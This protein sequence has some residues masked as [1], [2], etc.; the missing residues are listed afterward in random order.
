MT[1][2]AALAGAVLYLAL[3]TVVSLPETP[4]SA[5]RLPR[6]SIGDPVQMAWFL[7]W[8]AHAVLHGH[9]LF[10]TRVLDFPDGVNLALNTTVPVLGLAVLPVTA[11]AGPVVSFNL[12]AHL[13]LAASAT[14][15]YLVARRYVPSA[16]AA[17]LAG[18]LYGFGPYAAAH[19]QHLDLAFA[20]VPP[21]VLWCLDELF[22]RQ[23]RRPVRVGLALG[24]LA[25]FQAL[26]APEIL[27]TTAVLAAVGLA[28]L[29]LHRPR[30]VL[31]RLRRALPGLAA[32]A[33]LAGALCAYPLAYMLD[34]PQH[35][36]G[37]VQPLP[38]LQAL[39]ADLLSAV[40][41]TRH[42]WI[43][44]ASLRV[45]ADGFY[46]KNLSENAGYLGI[47]LL[48]FAIFVTIWR[49]KDGIVAVSAL[50]GGVAFLLSLGPRL[51]VDGHLTSVPLPF[52]LFAHVPLLDSAVP[53]REAL[54]VDLFAGLLLARGVDALRVRAAARRAARAGEVRRRPGRRRVGAALRPSLVAGAVGAAA[55]VPALPSLPFP[56]W[57]IRPGLAVDRVLAAHLPPRA[58]VLSYP[59]PSSSSDDTIMLWQAEGGLRYRLVGGYAIDPGPDRAGRV[60]APLL[61]PPS[62]EE[63]LAHDADVYEGMYPAPPPLSPAV[64]ADLRTF[65]GRYRVD[66]VIWTPV[67]D[68]PR[69]AFAYL[70]GGLGP[71]S[72]RVG[73]AAVWVDVPAI[74]ARAGTALS[75]PSA[76]T[77]PPP[78]GPN[79]ARNS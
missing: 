5:T 8:T 63:I 66:A 49:R 73:E 71:P 48:A 64:E 7:E 40:V 31:P 75:V 4:W 30:L 33:V 68:D 6:G 61:S 44:P 35:I 79:G 13:A 52:A 39:H 34:G 22:V 32:A 70:E 37:T 1:D 50:L 23:R 9:Q 12:L 62:V 55:L 18:L 21:L 28:A 57:P 54:Y 29:A 42:Q 16:P 78:T 36:I 67:G 25:T 10:F 20:P 53:G 43:A 2:R 38:A 74:L 58:V 41:P 59:F 47:P 26:V 72:A 45:L 24:G 3:A 76:A 46:H 51:A 14:S 77:A 69:A 60:H 27:A 15:C 19:Y 56:S 17:F 11:A 65:L